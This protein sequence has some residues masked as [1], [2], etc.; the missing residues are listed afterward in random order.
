MTV[1]CGFTEESWLQWQKG[2]GG[3]VSVIDCTDSSFWYEVWF[4]RREF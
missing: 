1:R 3:L 2:I 4:S